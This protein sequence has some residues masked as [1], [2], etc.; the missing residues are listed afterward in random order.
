MESI[1]ILG[2]KIDL[3]CNEVLG[4]ESDDE[5]LDDCEEALNDSSCK[6]RRVE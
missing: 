4:D 6:I 5:W 3:I 1:R 2:E